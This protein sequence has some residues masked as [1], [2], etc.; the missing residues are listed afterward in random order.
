M[1]K[2]LTLVSAALFVMNAHAEQYPYLSFQTTDGTI[3]SFATTSLAMTVADGRLVI[4]NDNES[5][6]IALAKLSKM[7]FS[8]SP[9]AVS[10][11]KGNEES[12]SAKVYDISG[13]YFGTLGSAGLNDSRLAPGTYIIKKNGKTKK[14]TKR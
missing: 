3:L 12:S 8:S 14:T 1:K 4:K 6:S 10:S 11:V 13:M 9:T 7:Y 5:G 2:M